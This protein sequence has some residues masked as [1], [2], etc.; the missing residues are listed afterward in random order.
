MKV[1]SPMRTPELNYGSM[2]DVRALFNVMNISEVAK[3]FF[4]SINK[5]ERRKNNY[6]ELTLNY[7]TL[8]FNK[9]AC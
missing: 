4:N 6:H 7:F 3:I 9:Y 8:L 2:D 5:S 1:I